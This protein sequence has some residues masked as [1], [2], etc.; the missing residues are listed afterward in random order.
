MAL[1]RA[2]TPVPRRRASAVPSRIVTDFAVTMR[3]A[4]LRP[5]RAC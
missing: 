4:A 2:A 5:A 3:V 1:A